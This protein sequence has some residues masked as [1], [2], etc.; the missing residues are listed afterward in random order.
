MKNLHEPAE[1]SVPAPQTRTPQAPGIGRSEFWL[2]SFIVI[3]FS[4]GLAAWA[5]KAAS[6]DRG[7]VLVF[8]C[9]SVILIGLQ[10]VLCAARL[11]NT[12]THPGWAFLSLVPLFSIVLLPRLLFIRPKYVEKPRFGVFGWSVVALCVLLLGAGIVWLFIVEFRHNRA[13]TEI[14]GLSAQTETIAGLRIEKGSLKWERTENTEPLE[15]DARWKESWKAED[16]DSG[17]LY[18]IT[19]TEHAGKADGYFYRRE[20]LS[21]G[22]SSFDNARIAGIPADGIYMERVFDGATVHGLHFLF[23]KDKTGWEISIMA[24]GKEEALHSFTAITRRIISVAE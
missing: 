2:L 15:A 11:R 5:E 24:P 23:A 14:S 8:I 4:S 1:D 13:S 20:T 10:T 17:I 18:H 3:I 22:D 7:D 16:H 19:R 6:P 21:P 12:G 9:L